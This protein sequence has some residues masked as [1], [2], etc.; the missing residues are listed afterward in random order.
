MNMQ[1]RQINDQF[2]RFLF[3]LKDIKNNENKEFRS[4]VYWPNK[5]KSITFD[6][7]EKSER[8]KKKLNE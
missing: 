5:N 6:F 7:R 8:K 3:S 1:T 2:D 4:I